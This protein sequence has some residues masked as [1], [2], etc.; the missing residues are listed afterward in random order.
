[1]ATKI[2]RTA[3]KIAAV[4]L[5]VVSAAGLT[6]VLPATHAAADG[7]TTAKGRV[8]ARTTL[9]ERSAPSTHA[10]IAGKGYRNGQT[11]KLDCNLFG[12][13][14]GGNATWYKIVGKDSWVA[15][16]YVKNIGNAPIACTAASVPADRHAKTTASVNLRQAPSTHDRVIGHIAKGK[17]AQ[18]WCK[19]ASQ[20]VDGNHTWYQ[21][22]NGWVAAKYVKTAKRIPY[23]SQ[24]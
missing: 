20:K 17:Q 12:T 5:S 23:C 19:V 4:T 21:E 11:I 24:L 13:S 8:T 9:A 6:A 16:R 3:G 1:M 14:V 2:N 7:G 22:S 10:P 18:L 15:A